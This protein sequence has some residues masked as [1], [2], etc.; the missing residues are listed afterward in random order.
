MKRLLT[1]LVMI[2]VLS[3]MGVGAAGK[4]ITEGEIVQAILASGIDCERADQVHIDHLEYFDFAGDGQEE[5]VVVASTCMTGTAGPDIHAVYGRDADGKVYELPIAGP[6]TVGEMTPSI[7][8][9]LFGN[10]NWSLHV[11]QGLLVESYA[12]T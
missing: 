10:I 11:D 3:P 6:K 4:K 5:A 1:S 8:G 2:L 9:R 7:Y 12:D